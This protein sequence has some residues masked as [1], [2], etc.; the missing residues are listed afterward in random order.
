MIG[1]PESEL[2]SGARASADQH[3][4][5][6]EMLDRSE[7]R[8][9]FSVFHLA[10]DEVALWETRAGFLRPERCIETYVRLAGAAG[11]TTRYR[12]PVRAWRAN[13]GGVEVTTDAGQYAAEQ[14]V[15]TCGARISSVVGASIPPVRAERAALFWMEPNDLDLSQYERIPIYLWNASDGGGFGFYGFPHV[16]WPGVKVARHHT[17]EF[18]D[19]DSVDRT[20]NASDES[21]IRHAIEKRM[22]SLNGRVL[23]GLIC[24]YENSPDGHF[25]I[26]RVAEHPNV[27]YAGGFSGHGFKFASV[28]G[29]ILADLV[30]RG[31]ATPDAD[32]LRAERLA[33]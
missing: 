20:V 8:A 17:G 3:G 29:E 24:L 30:T 22:P 15:F 21:A 28:V 14:V 19:P 11:A 31:S 13:A 2:V 32:F 26:D 7:V 12:E 25:I 4:L 9:R 6:Y 16:D 27:V 33:T 18:C 10:D 23:N 5:E 1:A